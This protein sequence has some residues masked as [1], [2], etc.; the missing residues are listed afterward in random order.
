MIGKGI[1]KV[2]DSVFWI[3]EQDRE[4]DRF[5][6]LWSLPYGVAY[7]SYLLKGDKNVLVDTVKC[8]FAGDFAGKIAAVLGGGTLDYAIVNHMEPDH[9]GSLGILRKIYPDVKLIGN[10]KTAEM[11]R[12]FLGVGDNVVIVKDGE[13]LDLGSRKFTF[14]LAPMVH[15]PESMA[16]Y[17]ATDKILFS[18][19]IFGAF[20]ATEGGI[21]DDE[22][23][24]DITESEMMR[25]Y[26]NI[27]GRFSSQASKA[28]ASLRALDIDV[29]CPSHGP[30]WRSD[31][32][33]VMG[34]YE[35]WS[36]Q[37]TDGGVAVVYGTMYGNTKSAADAI[38]GALSGK[39]VRGV[40]V[41][42]VARSDISQVITD[43]WR[44]SGLILAACTYNMEL[45]PPMAGLLSHI[46]NKNMRG[47][48]IGLCGMHSW[49]DAS[50]RHMSE[51]IE[52]SR[53]G[54][55]LV[56]PEILVKSSMKETDIEQCELLA[57]NMASAVKNR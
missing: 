6:G 40:R 32:G 49:A 36:N 19:D 20:G 55:S 37:E 52:R 50:L 35:K 23:D 46:E 22:A 51:F 44:K 8:S 53:G 5:E 39:G 4:T 24:M 31:P 38:S 42:D 15:W 21:F 13:S 29:I 27:V 17:D 12:N 18:N 3:G 48:K 1:V 11:L 43:I 16:S 14:A 2:A 7:N 54:W 33:R 57:S 28:L 56:K 47:R 34:L 10:P 45:F 9:S 41:Y 30:V 25:Y 26:V